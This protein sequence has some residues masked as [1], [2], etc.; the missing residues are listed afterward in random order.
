MR[1]RV[2]ML[3]WETHTGALLCKSSSSVML[4][5]L[6]LSASSCSSCEHIAHRSWRIHNG[7]VPPHLTASAAGLGCVLGAG[8]FGRS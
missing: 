1:L 7:M 8:T 2:R 3:L 6:L 5:S 4:F